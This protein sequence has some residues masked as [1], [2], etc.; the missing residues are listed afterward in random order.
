MKR[1][2]KQTL[3]YAVSILLMAAPIV[4]GIV[5]AYTTASDYRYIWVA[6]ASTLGV[7]LVMWIRKAAQASSTTSILA[8]VIAT[9]L[10][11]TVAMVTGAKPVPALMVASFFGFCSAAGAALSVRSRPQ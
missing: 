9:L 7:G 3:L 8:F 6:I 1:S 11:W 4:F 5:R 2:P 10:A